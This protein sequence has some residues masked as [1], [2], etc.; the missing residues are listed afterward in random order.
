MS[1]V[2]WISVIVLTLAIA[3]TTH[4]SGATLALGRALSDTSSGTG[5]QDAVIPV[6][7]SELR[8]RCIWT[9]L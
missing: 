5:Y 3:Y 9:Y 8:F 4:F 1:V 2:L 7:V 6:V